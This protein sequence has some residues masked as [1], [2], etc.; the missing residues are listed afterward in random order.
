MREAPPTTHGL[1][2]GDPSVAGVGSDLLDPV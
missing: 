1:G 2:R